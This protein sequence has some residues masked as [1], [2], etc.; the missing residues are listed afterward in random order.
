VFGLGH[1]E[2]CVS[3]KLLPWFNWAETTNLFHAGSIPGTNSIFDHLQAKG[4]PHRI[5][6]YHDGSDA[7]LLR[8]AQEDARGSG[9]QF[10]FVYLCEL[11]VFLHHH[12]EDRPAIE[13]RLRWYGTEMRTL[14]DTARASDRAAS[15]TIFSDHGMTPVEAHIDLAGEVE[16]LGFR[17]PYE[18]LAVY[19]ATMA[20]FWFFSDRA[21]TGIQSHLESIFC[22]H[23]LSDEE[24]R[25]LGILF[26]DN[27]YGETIF[28]M[29]PGH[30]I[31]SSG[32]NRKQYMPSGM[33]GY[34]PDDPNSDA[35]YLSTEPLPSRLSGIHELYGL[36]QR[37]AA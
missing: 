30:L 17:M 10:L 34:H 29:N 6:S 16:K 2:C 36:M 21:K 25:A 3:P 23:I 28:L 33:H 24:R 18:Y 27:R 9:V 12:C 5:Y 8:R 14:L 4:V 37:A 15:L 1:F 26:A 22:G 19:D 11:D 32:F 13:E 20:R 31:T 35:C 7:E